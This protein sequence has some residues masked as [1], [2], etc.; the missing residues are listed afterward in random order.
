MEGPRVKAVPDVLRLTL[1]SIPTKNTFFNIWSFGDD[2]K[3][4]WPSNKVYPSDSVAE[5]TAHVDKA[6]ADYGE[7]EIA[8]ALTAVY[9]NVK[10]GYESAELKNGTASGPELVPTSAFVLTDPKAWDLAS[11]VEVVRTASEDAKA[12]G[13]LLRT[14]VLGV[15][16][17]VSTP[18][19]DG[20]ARAGR[21][22]SVFVSVSLIHR[23]FL[24]TVTDVYKQDNEKPEKK[25]KGLLRS[26]R[27]GVI[28]D[29]RVDWGVS[30]PSPASP[31]EE[32]FETVNVPSAAT[33][34][35]PLFSTAE[36]SEP[37]RS[38][39]NQFRLHL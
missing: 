34:S 18:M 27:G 2:H 25:L 19:C 32:D 17:N 35:A 30:G 7:T 16:N 13:T 8:K 21:G 4:L 36:S 39:R 1:R 6:K 38:L 29:L 15:G 31:Q 11:V 23:S 28:D 20:I 26:A 10:A 12:V 24:V 37:L 3:S 14:F 9:A 22:I 5:A 33:V